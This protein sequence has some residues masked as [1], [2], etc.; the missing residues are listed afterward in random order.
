MTRRFYVEPPALEGDDVALAGGLAHR[1]SRVLRLRAGDEVVLFDGAGE[2]LV[3]IERITPERVEAAVVERREGAREPHVAVHLY[4][5]IS[6]GERFEWLIE[7]ATEVGVARFVPLVAARS[8]V[9]TSGDGNRLERWR[10]IAVEAAEQSGRGR[11]PA[12]EAPQ[13]FTPALEDARGVVL[14][15]YEGA[16]E[17]APG[18]HA[19]LNERIDELFALGEVSVF[20]GPEGGFEPAEVEQALAAGAAVVTMGERVLRSETA[21]LVA[22]TLVLH[23]TGELG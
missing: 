11:V 15:P 22:A 19:V 5:C 2:A 12:V 21:G 16:G 9:K 8:V 13:R 7:K 1:L 6:K 17:P 18:V 4:Q 3:R 23:A 14:L 10:R 20:I